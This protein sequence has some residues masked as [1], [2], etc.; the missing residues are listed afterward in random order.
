MAL[1]CCRLF[2][3][4]SGHGCWPPRP[5]CQ[6]SEDVIC[7]GLPCHRQSDMWMVHCCPPPI[8]ACHPSVLCEGSETVITNG[9]QQGRQMDP[10]C[11][12]SFVMC[13]SDD[14]FVGPG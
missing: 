9:L 10:V 7:N 1:G 5:N 4:C 11:C 2:D 3:C 12:G 14:T 8:V 13:G 6:G